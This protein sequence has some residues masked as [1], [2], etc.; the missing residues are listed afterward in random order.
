MEDAV[1][2]RAPNAFRLVQFDTPED[3]MGVRLVKVTI[4]SITA[5][6]ISKK[7]HLTFGGAVQPTLHCFIA[8]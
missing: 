2:C 7:S 3:D 8:C 5:S 4:P 1:V 6:V